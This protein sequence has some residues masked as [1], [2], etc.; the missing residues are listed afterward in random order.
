LS[1]S[2]FSL[3]RRLTSDVFPVVSP[4][5]PFA[6]KEDAANNYARGHYTIGREV[7]D[8]V[9]DRVRKL[10]DQVGVGDEACWWHSCRARVC[11]AS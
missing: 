5:S 7:I 8:L 3:A 2:F 6:Q 1:S 11:K 9:L 10:A 4:P